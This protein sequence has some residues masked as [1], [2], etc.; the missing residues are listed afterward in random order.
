MIQKVFIGAGSVSSTRI[1]LKS[2]KIFSK[3]IKLLAT[4]NFYIKNGFN[5]IRVVNNISVFSLK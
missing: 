3:T 4:E 1:Y 2:H 5:L